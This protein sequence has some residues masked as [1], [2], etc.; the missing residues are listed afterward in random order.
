MSDNH[1]AKLLAAVREKRGY[2]LPHHGLMAA[3]MPELLTAYDDLY[4]AMT[5]T[6]RQLSRHD[7][8]YVWMA[9]LM[10]TDEARATHHIP[11][12][13]DAG[14]THEELGSLLALTALARGGAAYCF[15]E[16]H[17]RGHLPEFEPRAHYL[18]AFR[19]VAGGAPPRLA[20]MAAA[21]V[22][23]CMANWTLFCW[24]LCAAYED[25]V[26]ETEFAEALSLTMFPGSVPYFVEAAGVW[27]DLILAGRLKASPGFT[28]WAQLSGQGGYDE[29]A[30]VIEPA[31]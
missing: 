14:G 19:Q 1:L 30:G 10:A 29:A 23:T 16:E 27:R 21:A 25:G 5:L 26:D 9:I 12:F 22:F 2:L 17:W 28:A 13:F 3:S 6:P 15:V 18:N 7:H 20:H 8:E 11:K 31:S 4:T 24:Q